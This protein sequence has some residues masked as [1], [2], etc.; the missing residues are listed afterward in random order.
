MSSIS[1]PQQLHLNVSIRD[2]ATLDNFYLPQGSKNIEAIKT[3]EQQLTLDKGS[4]LFL[5]GGSGS[6][7]THLLQGACHKLQNKGLTTVYLPLKEMAGYE[8]STLLEGLE[9]QHLVCLDGLDSIVGHPRW[10]RSLF[11]LFNQMKEQQHHLLVAATQG[12]HQIPIKLPD[13]QSRFSSGHTYQ[14]EVLSDQDKPAALQMRAKAR[15]MEM[16]EEVAQFILNRAPRDMNDLFYYLEQLDDLTL[17]AQR[18]LTI[19][20]VKEALGW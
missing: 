3:L 7:L 20:F 11:D 19:P 4:F 5:W 6:G 2:D 13:L 15:G 17:S 1:T 16:S 10:E 18:R 8:P 12:P 14:I 9:H